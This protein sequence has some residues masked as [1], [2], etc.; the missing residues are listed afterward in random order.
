MPL[1]MPDRDFFGRDQSA[2]IDYQLDLDVTY[3]SEL[4]SESSSLVPNVDDGR[5]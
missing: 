3:S 5:L 4:E 2:D 1:S